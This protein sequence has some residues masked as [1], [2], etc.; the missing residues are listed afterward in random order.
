MIPSVP[1][2]LRGGSAFA[3][4]FLLCSSLSAQEPPRAIVEGTVVNAI[5]GRQIPRAMVILRDFSGGVA[6]GRA[7][8]TGHFQIKNVSQGVY[9]VTADRPGFYTEKRRQRQLTIDVPASGVLGNVLIKLTPQSS[10]TGRIVDEH[11]DV[12]QH[13]EVMLLGW[14]FQSGRRILKKKLSAFTNDLGD[15]RL[16]PVQKGQYFLMAS[17]NARAEW[18]QAL[19]T[20]SG[21]EAHHSDI[22]SAPVFY[23]GTSNFRE[24]QEISI[25]PGDEVVHDFLLFLKPAVSVRGHVVNG[26]TGQPVPHPVVT[27]V[28]SPVPVGVEPVIANANDNGEFELW[29]LPPGSY[30]LSSSSPEEGGS[31]TGETEIEVAGLGLNNVEIAVLPDFKIAGHVRIEDPERSPIRRVSLAF[32]ITSGLANGTTSVNASAPEFLVPARLHPKTHYCVRAIGMPGD[33]YLKSVAVSGGEVPANDVVVEGQQS[34]IEFT[35]SP[36]GGHIDGTVLTAR[37]EPVYNSLVML[38][39]DTG[40]ID[41]NMIDVARSDGNGKFSIRGV[42]PGSYRILAWEEVNAQELFAQADTLK[43]FAGQGDALKVEESGKYT[44]YPKLIP[45]ESAP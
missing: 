19:N 42:A 36:N 6:V 11:N 41:P 33:F 35:I 16:F 29:G 30:T 23:P 34:A 2:C 26:L 1:P 27:A 3:F 7:D 10:I 18:L 40:I 17:Y 38:I 14:E 21:V 32:T 28:W 45:A 22:A 20:P 12:V 37:N 43:T 4:L 24:A 5:N 15:Y 44:V 39:P 31:Y 25:R 9:I 13:V 8:D